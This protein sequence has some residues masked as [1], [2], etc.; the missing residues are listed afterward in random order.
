[1]ISITTG[2]KSFDAVLGG[3]VQTQSMTEG[4]SLE[5]LKHEESLIT[6]LPLQSTAS[7][8]M[9]LCTPDRDE[10]KLISPRARRRTGKTQLCH[11][12]CVTAQLPVDMGGGEGKV[13]PCLLQDF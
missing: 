10:H 7:S 13:N 1:M 8:G 2:S 5:L 12:L 4:R 3:G 9:S 11:T 6:L